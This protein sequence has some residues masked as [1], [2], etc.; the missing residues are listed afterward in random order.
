MI[1]FFF[2]F[3]VNLKMKKNSQKGK[4]VFHWN[5]IGIEIRNIVLKL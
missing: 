1:I 5:I 4:F 2:I 3:V